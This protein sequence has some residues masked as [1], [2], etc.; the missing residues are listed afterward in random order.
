MPIVECL[1]WI[2]EEWNQETHKGIPTPGR[3]EKNADKVNNYSSSEE[4]AT[5]TWS[6]G[7]YD[8]NQDPYLNDPTLHIFQGGNF[9]LSVR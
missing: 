8:V 4:T 6:P 1:L 2:L 7:Q 3:I 5:E 9:I